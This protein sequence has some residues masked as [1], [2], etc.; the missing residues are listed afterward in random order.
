MSISR[1][2]GA[3]KPAAKRPRSYMEEP[4]GRKLSIVSTVLHKTPCQ[5]SKEQMLGFWGYVRQN[6]SPHHEHQ[7]GFGGRKASHQTP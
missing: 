7:Q 6:K 2:F 5:K 3:E 1:A 4:C